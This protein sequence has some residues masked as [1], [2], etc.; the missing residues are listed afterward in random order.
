MLK[1]VAVA[2][3]AKTTIWNQSMPK[4]HRYNGTAVSVSTNVP[5]RNELVVQLIRSI[6]IREIT[7]KISGRRVIQVLTGDCAAKNHVILGPGMNL[8]A[9]RTGE[10]LRFNCGCLPELFFDCPPGIGEL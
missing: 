9:V 6:G 2:R 3:I 10:L 4:Y 5:M 8:A 1:P 7:W